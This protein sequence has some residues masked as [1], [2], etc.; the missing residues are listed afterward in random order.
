YRLPKKLIPQAIRSNGIAVKSLM[1][2]SVIWHRSCLRTVR[3]SVNL[4]RQFLM[5][6]KLFF[7]Q[8]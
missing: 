1:H 7:I 2:C 8:F 6:L 4:E 5:I 3:L